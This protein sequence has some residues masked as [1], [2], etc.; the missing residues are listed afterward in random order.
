GLLNLI[1]VQA[2]VENLPAE[3]NKV[4]DEIHIHFPWGSL[5]RAVTT[6]DADVLGSL[7]RISSPGCV[8]EVVVGIDPQRDQAELERLNIPALSQEYVDTMLA[9]RYLAAGFKM[10]ETG[11]IAPADWRTLQ[12]CW[13]RRL[14][15]GNR[16]VVYFIAEAQ[17]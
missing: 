14:R 15:P 12:T 8:L 1:F 6:A 11:T 17:E 16:R 3:L 10:M 5:L 4:A 7:Y 13:A 2:A 9:P